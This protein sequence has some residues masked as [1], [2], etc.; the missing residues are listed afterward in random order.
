M[1]E[2]C[3]DS[4]SK[5][6]VPLH[7]ALDA[8]CG[9][10]RTA[11]E[12]ANHFRHV[13]AYD[14]SQGFVDMC[15]KERDQ[16]GLTNLTVY[17]GDSHKQKDL[18]EHRFDL[19]FGCNLIDRLHTPRE[20][21]EQSKAMLKEGG[22][23]VVA[24]PYTWRPEYT[25]L[26]HWIGGFHKDAENYFT[27]DGLRACMLPELVLLEELKVPFVIPDPDGSYQ[28]TYSN[29]TVFGTHTKL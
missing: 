11:L 12:L 13:E 27:V 17:Q 9:P 19:I 4:C 22:I 10:G 2:V 1:A 8:G 21:I 16:Q 6:A 7:S 14:Y 5:H 18:T 26:E 24:S 29:V 20:W 15:C 23:L 28:Y 3:L 25:P